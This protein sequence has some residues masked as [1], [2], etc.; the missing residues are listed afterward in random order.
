MMLNDIAAAGG[1]RIPDPAAG[2]GAA[3]PAL[4]VDALP[5]SAQICSCND[6][7]KGAI[8]A[9]VARRRL[10]ASAPSKAAPTPAPA[11]G[12][13]V[14]L[15]TQIMKAEMKK[16]GLAVNNHLCEHFAVLAPGDCSTWCASAASRPSASCWPGTARAWAATSASRPPPA[17]SP[18]CWNEFVLKPVHA[19][20]A[21]HQRLLPRQYPEGRHL[22]GGAAHAGR[23]GHAGRPDRGRPG[24]EE[25][26]P[27]HQDHRRPA[28]RPVRRARRPAAG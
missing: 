27:V 26:R 1:A 23:R 22:F 24:G 4:G 13:C 16:P 8:C 3:R 28:R 12:G 9:A 5:A 7:S 20:P 25:I 10:P 19:G 18:R 6:V 14:P 15:V 17:S 11:C 21:G 2:D